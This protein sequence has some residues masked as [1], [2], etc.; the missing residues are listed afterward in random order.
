[1]K[2]DGSMARVPDLL[3]F[4]AT[5]KLLMVTVA[6]LVAYRLQKDPIVRAAETHTSETQWGTVTVHK[7]Q[8]ILDGDLHLAFQM[9][10]ITRQLPLVRV[11]I[12]ELPHDLDGFGATEPSTFHASMKAIKEDGCGVLVY[13]RHPPRD[14][15]PSD[16]PAHR[17]VG[18]GAQIL[19]QLGITKMRLLTRQEKKYI[20]L[21]GFG[22]DIVSHVPLV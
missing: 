16:E 5:H 1:M 8:N 21:K 13:L 18:I 19:G 2:D 9:G 4:C 14:V 12:E 22:L 3:K 20:G 6:D 15:E 17:E 7:F 11:H 10:D